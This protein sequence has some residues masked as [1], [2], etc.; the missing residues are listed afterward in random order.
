MILNTESSEFLFTIDVSVKGLQ[1]KNNQ[2]SDIFLLK[3]I[4]MVLDYYQ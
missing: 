4:L 3:D 1:Q 2:Y